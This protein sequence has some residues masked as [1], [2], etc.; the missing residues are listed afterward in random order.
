MDYRKLILP[1][2]PRPYSL[3]RWTKPRNRPVKSHIFSQ[4]VGNW[5]RA[6]MCNRTWRCAGGCGAGHSFTA[7]LLD[8]DRVRASIQVL[9]Q[10]QSIKLDKIKIHQASKKQKRIQ[11]GS[12]ASTTFR[13]S[14]TRR[15]TR[16][17]WLDF[18]FKLCRCWNP[19]R[20]CAS[21]SKRVANWDFL[22][23]FFFFVCVLLLES[24]WSRLEKSVNHTCDT[25]IGFIPLP[26]KNTFIYRLKVSF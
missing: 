10:L 15:F 4:L 21:Q 8:M 2:T 11:K 3:P 12:E 1:P 20:H 26:P 23:S 19:L 18:C 9:L 24:V 17:P 22:F 14:H 25:S 13:W 5:K 6:T 16:G 7:L